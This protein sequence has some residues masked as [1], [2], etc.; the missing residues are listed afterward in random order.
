MVIRE[1]GLACTF[2]HKVWPAGTDHCG[3]CG[4]L[5]VPFLVTPSDAELLDTVAGFLREVYA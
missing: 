5:L 3:Q 2:C 4:C 1:T